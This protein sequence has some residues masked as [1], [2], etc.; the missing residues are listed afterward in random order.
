MSELSNGYHSHSNFRFA[1][2]SRE[3]EAVLERDYVNGAS[4][5]AIAHKLGRTRSGIQNRVSVYGL[6]RK[7]PLAKPAPSQPKPQPQLQSQPHHW[8]DLTSLLAVGQRWS[9]YLKVTQDLFL[10][11]I[12]AVRRSLS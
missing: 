1:R 10:E 4:I 3:D 7:R 8:R 9:S 11:R 2:W 6:V 12:G 5:E